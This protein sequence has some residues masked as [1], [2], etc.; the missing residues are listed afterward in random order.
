MQSFPDDF[1]L[2]PT[3]A[4]AYKQLGNSVNVEVVRMFAKFLIFRDRFDPADYG[5][6]WIGERGEQP[7]GP[8]AGRGA[9]LTG[10]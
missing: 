8:R 7:R 9:E 5:L 3:D 2:H 4:L 6:E 10:A 1:K